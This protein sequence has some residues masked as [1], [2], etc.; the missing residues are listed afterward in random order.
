MHACILSFL[1]QLGIMQ[2]LAT[3]TVTKGYRLDCVCR[4]VG[5]VVSLS[6][7]CCQ[8]WAEQI[9]RYTCGPADH[10]KFIGIFQI[11]F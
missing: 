1:L 3:V 6:S 5:L 8:L 4:V 7:S 2:I 9:T 11:Y 10:L